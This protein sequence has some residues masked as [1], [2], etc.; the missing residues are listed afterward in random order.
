MSAAANAVARKPVTAVASP[1]SPANSFRRDLPGGEQEILG[2]ADIRTT[3][4]I[5]THTMKRR[6]DDSG[7]KMAALAGLSNLGN[8]RE[9]RGCVTHEESELSACFSGSPGWNRTNDQRI[10]SPTLYR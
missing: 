7:D 5:Y 2:H 6:H 8:K 1:A 10:N 3:L 4:A 9:T